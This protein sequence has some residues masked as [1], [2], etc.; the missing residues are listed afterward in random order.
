MSHLS[1]PDKLHWFIFSF[2]MILSSILDEDLGL[3]FINSLP[4]DRAFASLV[5]LKSV[6]GWNGAPAMVKGQ[7]GPEVK[8]SAGMALTWRSAGSIL[9]QTLYF[10]SSVRSARPG[11]TA[12]AG[13][14]IAL[15]G[16]G[17]TWQSYKINHL[18]RE[19]LPPP[20]LFSNVWIFFLYLTDIILLMTILF[21]VCSV[22]PPLGDA[23]IHLA[24]HTQ[25]LLFSLLQ[26][27]LLRST[28]AIKQ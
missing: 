13:G 27:F 28:P 19:S 12:L 15:H 17:H 9:T 11:S 24:T 10:A 18:Q 3:I 4:G 21:L 23:C 1:C 20:S 14:L 6:C 22:K 8:W 26:N 16:K 25:S 5:I 7:F 2:S